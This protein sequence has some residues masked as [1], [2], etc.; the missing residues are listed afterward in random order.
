MLIQG[1]YCVYAIHNTK[2]FYLGKIDDLNDKIRWLNESNRFK[3]D[4][5]KT[6]IS[7]RD[8]AREFA[9]KTEYE[10]HRMIINKDLQIWRVRAKYNKEHKSLMAFRLWHLKCAP[11]NHKKTVD[12]EVAAYKKMTISELHEI[13]KY[14]YD[15]WKKDHVSSAKYWKKDLKKSKK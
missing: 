7:Q 3:S 8:S 10:K 13:E 4:Q 6:L 9:E 15:H 1:A 12:E 14:F 5:N 11:S 2:K